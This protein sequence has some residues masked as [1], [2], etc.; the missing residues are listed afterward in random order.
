VK[1][2]TTYLIVLAGPTAVGKT[3]VSISLAQN[4]NCEIISADSRQFYKE[5][6]IG[7]APPEPEQLQKI[8]HHFVGFKTI[9]EY[10]NVSRYE[11]DVIKIL[12]KL[13]EINQI[14]IMTGGS[15]L[16]IDAACNGIDDMPDFD[17]ELREQ[18]T[19]RMNTEGVESLRIELKNLD[20]LTYERIDLRNKNRI[21]RALEMCLLTGKPYSDFLLKTPKKRPFNIIKIALNMNRAE[22]HNRINQRTDK[23][24]EAGLLDEAKSLFP[25]RQHNAL[26][27]VGYKELFDYFDEKTSLTEAIE[28]IKRNTRRYARKQISWFN[29]NND[30]TWF[31]PGQ[32]AEIVNFIQ[33]K[34]N[35]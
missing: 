31:A 1:N 22:L 16:Y 12:P 7:A 17:P 25:F 24:I 2:N 27:T 10:Y 20:P 18:L 28:L 26:K 30:Y 33:S 4:F 35:G 14:V 23:M 13:F 21:F 19:Q 5:L 8:K 15:G 9:S 11:Q 32:F 6:K 29:R 3:D 34:K